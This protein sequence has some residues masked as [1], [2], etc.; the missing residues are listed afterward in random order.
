MRRERS[1]KRLIKCEKEKRKIE[2]KRQ[3]EKAAWNEEA[4][5]R[6]ESLLQKKKLHAYQEKI[7]ESAISGK[8]KT[9]EMS[10]W[11]DASLCGCLKGWLSANENEELKKQNERRAKTLPAHLPKSKRRKWLWRNNQ[12]AVDAQTSAKTWNR[13]AKARSCEARRKQRLICIREAVS[14]LERLL[15]G[16]SEI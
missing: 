13:L 11:L 3:A 1:M 14:S 15:T 10:A 5:R 2:R 6:V 12:A 16:Y 7:K 9:Y 4:W 8:K